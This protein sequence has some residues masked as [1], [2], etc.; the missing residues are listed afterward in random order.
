M[1]QDQYS[2]NDAGLWNVSQYGYPAPAPAPATPTSV[3]QLTNNNSYY[4]VETNGAGAVD[5]SAGP[6]LQEPK[7]YADWGAQG[8]GEK[9]PGQYQG[10]PQGYLTPPDRYAGYQLPTPAPHGMRDKH[11]SCVGFPW[12]S[13]FPSRVGLHGAGFIVFVCTT[14]YILVMFFLR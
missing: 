11:F 7:E 10:Y 1:F 4:A 14:P 5:L 2:Y 12:I 6:R 3:S 9:Y 8:A 13:S